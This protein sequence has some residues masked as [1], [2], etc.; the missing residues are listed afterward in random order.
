M[1]AF[2]S[3]ETLSDNSDGRLADVPPEYWA[4]LDK[5]GDCVVD[6]SAAPTSATATEVIC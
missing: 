6:S 5:N 4:R 2:H 3:F 1:S